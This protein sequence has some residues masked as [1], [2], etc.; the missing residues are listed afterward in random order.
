[1]MSMK[2]AETNEVLWSSRRWDKDEMFAGVME[3]ISE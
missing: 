3:G 2:D 1:M